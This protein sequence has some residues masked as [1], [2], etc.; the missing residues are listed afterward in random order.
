MQIAE[1]VENIKNKKYEFSRHA[2]DQSILRNID[3]SEIEQ[4]IIENALIIEDYPDDK[5]GPSCLILG[6]TK[7]DRPLHIQCGYSGDHI[8]K[9]I[10]LYQPDPELWIDNKIRK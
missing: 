6:Y 7:S 5:Y 1:I 9:F 2:V 8:I 4:A 10:T 3:V